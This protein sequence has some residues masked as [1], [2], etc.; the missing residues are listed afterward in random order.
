MSTR[1]SVALWNGLLPPPLSHLRNCTYR[2]AASRY[3]WAD[4]ALGCVSLVT[5]SALRLYTKNS[6][7]LSV[8]FSAIF[9]NRPEFFA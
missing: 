8:V 3:P 7:I 4:T 5:L 2:P 6:L 9:S 1:I